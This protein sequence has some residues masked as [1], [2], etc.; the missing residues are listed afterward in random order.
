MGIAVAYETTQSSHDRTGLDRVITHARSHEGYV[1]GWY[2]SA[3][4]L[5]YFD[6]V[7]LFP[8]DSLSAAIDFGKANHQD[9]IYKLSS[10]EE[11]RLIEDVEYVS[12]TNLIIMYDTEIGKKDLLQAVKDYGADLLYDY[13]IIPGIAIRIPEGSDILKAIAFFEKVKGVTAVER[14]HIYHLIEPVKPKLEVM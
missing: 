2:N 6:S 12:P 13:S 5:Y 11:I 8:E 7:R 10:G 4:S 9:A 3:D 1:G 14:D